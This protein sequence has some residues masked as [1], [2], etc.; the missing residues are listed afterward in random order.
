MNGCAQGKR[1][2][3]YDLSSTSEDA[4]FDVDDDDQTKVTITNLFAATKLK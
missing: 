3:V 4:Y 2:A 1:Q